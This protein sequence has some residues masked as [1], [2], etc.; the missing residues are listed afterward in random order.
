MRLQE[1]LGHVKNWAN[2]IHERNF[3]HFSLWKRYLRTYG[4]LSTAIATFGGR[5]A[6]ELFWCYSWLCIPSWSFLYIIFSISCI[7]HKSVTYRRT[8]GRTDGPTD[9]RTDTPSYRDA[10][11]HLKKKCQWRGRNSTENTHSHAL[12]RTCTPTEE[13]SFFQG[14]PWECQRLYLK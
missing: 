9:R 2:L 5:H 8:D 10:R 13:V 1:F 4:N 3:G 6:R 12:S 11:T 14:F 7:F